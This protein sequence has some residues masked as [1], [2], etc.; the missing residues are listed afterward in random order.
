MAY[1]VSDFYN[2]FSDNLNLIAGQGGLAREITSCGILDYELL[3]ELKDKYFHSNFH[4][5]QFIVTSLLY[6]KDN[7]YIIA[8]AV[9]HLASKGCSGLVIR[10]VLKIQIPEAVIRYADSKNFSIFQVN[11]VTLPFETIIYTINRHFELEQN[12]GFH[13]GIINQILTQNL[14]PDEIRKSALN[15]NPSFSDQYFCIYCRLDDFVT[16]SQ[17]NQFISNYKASTLWSL[18]DFICVFRDGLLLVK[19]SEQLYDYYNSDFIRQFIAETFRDESIYNIGVSGTHNTLTEFRQALNEMFFASAYNVRESEK[20]QYY[21]DLGTYKAIF[22]FCQSAELRSF[23]SSIMDIIEEYDT[24]NSTYL[25]ETLIAY[26]HC[27]SS[28]SE[29]ALLLKQHE[30][31]I[32]YRLNKIYSLTGLNRKSPSDVEQLSLACKIHIANRLLSK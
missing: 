23:S 9:K 17:K 2:T 18:E 31:T 3:P 20:I 1:T 8:D 32:R 5:G 16:D 15:L 22:P 25:T 4:N 7:P 11:S 10:N 12:A 13:R 21:K 24:E 30:Q 26:I 29:T 27:D 14:S 28:L 19:S 6:A